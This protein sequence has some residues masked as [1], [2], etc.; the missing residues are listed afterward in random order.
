[1]RAWLAEQSVGLKCPTTGDAEALVKRKP[2]GTQHEIDE[3]PK[4][5]ERGSSQLRSGETTVGDEI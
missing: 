3:T 5:F 4:G 1:M 2:R